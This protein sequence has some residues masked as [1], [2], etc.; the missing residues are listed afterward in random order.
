MTENHQIHFDNIKTTIANAAKNTHF[1][2]TFEKPV[3]CDASRQGLGAAV[4][5][6]DK[7]LLLHPVFLT[8]M[9]NGTLLMN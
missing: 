5:K 7:L 1:N 6:D 4:S 9:K 3:K 8:I 2:P